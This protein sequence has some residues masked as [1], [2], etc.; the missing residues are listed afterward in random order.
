MTMQNHFSMN[1]TAA[2]AQARSAA[3][4]PVSVCS[5]AA[6]TLT[7]VLDAAAQAAS[8]IFASTS[9]CIISIIINIRMPRPNV[10]NP[11]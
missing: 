4:C 11:A 9:I 10:W 6:Q 8:I 2:M 1:H 3:V 7:I 5:S